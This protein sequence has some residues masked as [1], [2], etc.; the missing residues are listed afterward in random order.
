M[1][2]RAGPC[3]GQKDQALV[4]RAVASDLRVCRPLAAVGEGAAYAFLTCGYDGDP[5]GHVVG[6]IH[7]KAIPV[8]LHEED[9]DHWLRAPLGNA[10]S[11]DCAFPSQLLSRQ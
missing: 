11:L 9:F 10:L 3:D 7:P 8:I 4:R 1:V 5:A 2:G 6:A